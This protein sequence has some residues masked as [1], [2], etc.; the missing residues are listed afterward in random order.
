[1]PHERQFDAASPNALAGHAI[2]HHHRFTGKTLSNSNPVLRSC[3][4]DSGLALRPLIADILGLADSMVA[5]VRGYNLT[6]HPGRCGESIIAFSLLT[7]TSYNQAMSTSTA[8]TGIADH[9]R[10]TE[11]E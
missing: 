2:L 7:T 3:F 11:D 1:M 6:L 10:C 4:R 5:V 8:A 9:R